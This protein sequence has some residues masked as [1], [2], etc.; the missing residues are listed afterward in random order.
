[1][2]ML[3]SLLLVLIAVCQQSLAYAQPIRIGLIAS[4][5]GFAAPYGVAVKEGVE[6]ALLQLR[7][8]G[9]QIELFIED[10]QSDPAKVISAYRYLK[11]VK[12]VQ[13]VI[14][15][16]WW[17][18]PLGKI[19]ERD[20]IP[21]L[22][23]ETMQDK[24]FVPS[25]TYFLLS[26]R[27]ADWVRVYDPV[28]RA[29]G[30]RRAAVVRFTSGFGQSI[31]DEMR[32]LFS[33]PGREFLGEVEYQDLRFSEASSI[34]VRLK[35]MNPDVT[36]VDGQPEGLANLL[37]RRGEM[38]LQSI[39]V[40]GHTGLETAITQKLVSPEYIRN[41][42]FLRRKAPTADF[43]KRFELKYGRSP[44]LNSDLGYS[45]AQMFVRALKTVD[46]LAT[47]RKG[48]TIDGMV[49][50]FD[51]DQVSDGVAQEIFRMSDNGEAVRVVGA[52]AGR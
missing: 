21:L 17:V 23:C 14:G 32:R 5:T 41:V 35:R 25:K 22:S 44:V 37:K 16:S 13:G 3:C 15:G 45:A 30:M 33:T 42:Y 1:M 11:D 52:S 24:D 18:R 4:L 9:E 12:K 49:F 47:L 50:S 40:V 19:T 10:D 51:A 20:S 7:E 26:G 36:Y 29:Q 46:P 2:R 27:V 34:V 6:L 43:S 48:M 38:G 8:G 39:P 28:F 31:S